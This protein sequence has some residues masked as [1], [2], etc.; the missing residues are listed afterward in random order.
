[1]KLT[2]PANNNVKV[3]FQ[4][5][6]GLEPPEKR[7]DTDEKVKPKSF[8]CKMHPNKK[9]SAEF[10]VKIYAFSDGSPEE[11]IETLKQLTVVQVGQNVKKNED[12]V[13]LI[14]RFSKGLCL[15]PSKT[16]SRMMTTLQSRMMSL[17]EAEMP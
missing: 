11:Y 15:K 2:N 10:L 12:I 16:N 3:D 5:S 9:D 14:N 13:V 8:T 4:L 6:I 7:N 17:I 1:M